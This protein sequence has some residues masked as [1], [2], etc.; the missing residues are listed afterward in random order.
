MGAEDDD[1]ALALIS[2]KFFERYGQFFVLRHG[3]YRMKSF[4]TVVQDM[5]ARQNARGKQPGLNS[6]V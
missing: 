1:A 3:K 4:Q 2:T 5:S 6:Q